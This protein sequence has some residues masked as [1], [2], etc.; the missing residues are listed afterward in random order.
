MP[1][2]ITCPSC[3]ATLRLDEAHLGKKIQ[4]ANCKTVFVAAVSTPPAAEEPMA[5]EMVEEP[6]PTVT[7]AATGIQASKKPNVVPKP[8]PVAS[9]PP[10][11]P[12]KTRPATRRDRVPA[13][14]GASVLLIIALV[15]GLGLGGF[16]L[17]GC[18]GAIT[19]FM[20]RAEPAAR[21]PIAQMPVP[22][23]INPIFVPKDEAK[24]PQMPIEL[25]KDPPI[26]PEPAQ[27]PFIDPRKDLADPDV[28]KEKKFPDPGPKLPPPVPEVALTAKFAPPNPAA[29]AL[30]PSKLE[31]DRVTRMLPG[32]LDDIAVGGGGRFLL[33]NL[34]Q[35]RKIGMFDV[36]EGKVVHYFTT[37]GDDVK[38]TAGLTKLV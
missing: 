2:S 8:P 28:F 34:P 29:L 24:G 38:F 36:N 6:A 37:A 22:Q 11:S 10:K 21:P 18:L 27:P 3:Q 35:L 14:G 16:G 13:S 26:G 1:V 17:L 5:A 4:C 32:T 30:K 31:A 25:P 23:P 33:F 7:D 9:D 19:Y 12:A 15:G 20:L